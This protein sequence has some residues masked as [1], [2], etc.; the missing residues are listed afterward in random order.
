MPPEHRV[1]DAEKHYYERLQQF[2]AEQV[3]P[4]G[5]VLVGSS[6]FEWFETD[7]FLPG[8]RFVNRGI[9]SDRLGLGERGLL[10]RL[11]ISVFDVQPS[12]IVFNNGANDLGELWRNGKP[13]L[14]E[15]CEAYTRVIAAIRAGTADVPLLIVNEL[16]T[17]G[18]FAGLNPLVPPLNAHISD[19]AAQHGC[20]HLGFHHVVVDGRGALRDE[21]TTDGLH[22]NDAGYGLL[23]ERL[24]KLLPPV[25]A[26]V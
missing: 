10:H 21:L 2:A 5:I 15:I 17:T 26:H 11:D 12:F 22:L 7:R 25:Q 3:E 20:G 23:A 8:R 9:A 6:H 13:A 19:V 18:R 16:P 14:A 4:G 1:I 24:D